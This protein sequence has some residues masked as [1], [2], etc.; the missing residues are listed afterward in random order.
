MRDPAA[1]AEIVAT[2]VAA[3]ARVLV[4][5]ATVAQA[6][7]TQLAIEARLRLDHPALFRVGQTVVMRHGR[8]AF[9]DR[10]KLDQAVAAAFGK[11]AAASPVAR[12]LSGLG[13]R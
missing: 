2:A 13:R 4:L 10:R 1:V 6:V 11:P 3:G 7:A 9:E 12:S 8:Y 5:R